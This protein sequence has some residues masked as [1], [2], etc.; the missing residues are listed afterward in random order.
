MKEKAIRDFAEGNEIAPGQ[1]AVRTLGGGNV[2]EVY[3][4]RDEERLG[5]IPVVLAKTI[6]Q[7]L[8]PEPGARPTAA[9]LVKTLGEYQASEARTASAVVA[10]RNSSRP[11]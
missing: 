7:C 5:N 6:M 11:P 8:S 4:A 3:L 2:F 1:R 9:Q 10:S